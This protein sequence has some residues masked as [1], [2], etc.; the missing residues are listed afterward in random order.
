[1]SLL[2][3]R[4]LHA[5]VIK[6]HARGLEPLDTVLSLFPIVRSVDPNCPVVSRISM[7]LGRRNNATP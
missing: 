1:M 3:G 7:A 2:P 4:L 6:A 5:Y